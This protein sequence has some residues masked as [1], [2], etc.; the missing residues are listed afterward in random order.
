MEAQAD[1]QALDRDSEQMAI[2]PF[3][4]TRHPLLHRDRANAA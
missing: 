3:F 1:E 4:P 2:A